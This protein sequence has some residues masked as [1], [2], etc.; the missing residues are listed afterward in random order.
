MTPMPAPS[1][2]PP[3]RPQAGDDGQQGKEQ[4]AP[5]LEVRRLTTHFPT[6]RGIV[7]AV[8]DVSFAVRPG[9]TI[10]LVGESGSGKSTVLR[11][12]LGL[13]KP[14]GRIVEGEIVFNGHDLRRLPEPELRKIRG[15]Q[16][17][18]IF[19][20]PVNAFNPA[21]TIGDQLRR[22]LKLHR[23][24]VPAGGYDAEIIRMLA[25]IGVDGRGKLSSYPF[26]FSQGQLQRIMIAAACLGGAPSLLLADEPTTSLDVTI[27][28]QVLQLLRDLRQDLGLALVLV[29]HNLA[30]V[31]ELCDR[32]LVMYGGRLVEDGDVYT[33]FEQPS[34]PYTQQLLKTI[35]TFPHTGE[36]LYAMRGNVPDLVGPAPGCAFAPRCEQY[37]GPVSDTTR[38]DLWETA[39]PGQRAA[40]HLYRPASEPSSVGRA[41]SAQPPPP[42]TGSG[43]VVIPLALGVD[44]RVDSEDEG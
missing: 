18:T 28:A 17:G 16:I 26:N 14:P 31:A 15:G 3:A 6:G 20:D 29:T 7:R 1:D 33:I 42:P 36:R 32:V 9:E 10:G 27:E 30:L 13:L 38:P 35:P 11:S 44:S 19:Q 34:H 22:I 23:S 21:F 8:S 41:P 12:L 4:S 37:I 39:V 5:I 40:C 24:V 43:G 25:R 2:K